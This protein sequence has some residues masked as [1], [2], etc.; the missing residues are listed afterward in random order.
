MS[1]DELLAL[2]LRKLR[3]PLERVYHGNPFYRAKLDA[4]GVKSE[5]I[6]SLADFVRRVPLST[7]AEFLRDQEEHP[8]FGRRLGIAREEVALVTLTG[9]TS[10]QGQEVY[11]RS[12]QDVAYQ[13]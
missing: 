9:G 6:R 4:A 11:G 13:G 5:Q 3:R 12:Q 2:Q 8:L 7:K 10:G 1:R